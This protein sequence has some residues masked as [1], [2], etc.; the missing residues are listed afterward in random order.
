[1]IDSDNII[2]ELLTVTA[3]MSDPHDGDRA[4]EREHVR[5]ILDRAADHVGMDAEGR[6]WTLAHNAY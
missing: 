3:E 5:A 4:F 1:M 6:W 2:R